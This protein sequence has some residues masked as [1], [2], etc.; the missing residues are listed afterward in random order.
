MAKKKIGIIDA[1]L[2]DHGTRHPNLALMKISGFYKDPDPIKGCGQICDVELIT[3]K[4][5]INTIFSP[6]NDYDLIFVSKVFSFSKTPFDTLVDDKTITPNHNEYRKYILGGTG[7]FGID[8]PKLKTEIEHHMPDYHL[9]DDWVSSQIEDGKKASSFIDYTNFSIGFTTRGC[10]RHCPFC[11]NQKCNRVEQHS[12]VNEFLDT[13]RSKIY[14]WD[15]NVLGYPKWKEIFDE[16]DATKKPF[17]FRQGLD[18]RLMTPEKAERLGRSKWYGDFIFA[19]DNWEDRSIIEKNLKV[20]KKYNP[21]KGT[22]FYLFCGF[23]LTK[24]SDKKLLKDI[25]E[26]FYRIRILMQ[27]GCV[28]Y[29]MR[30]QDY[31]NHPLSNIYVQ[32][33]RWCNQQQFYKKMSFW[34]F[35]YRNQSYY[36]EKALGIVDKPQLKDFEDFMTDYK[37]GYYKKN[38]I[39]ICKSLQ[40]FLDF[41]NHYQTDTEEL[42]DLF[43][44]KMIG[45]KNT[46]LWE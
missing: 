1:D 43:N 29:V 22:K 14:L 38:K 4:F 20:W 15:D 39:K 24:N 36:E 19:F 27:Y 7:F 17:Q 46:K 25:K 32:I 33:A 30:H 45:L 11:V 3:K 2:L 40:T 35:I 31:L 21:K 42:L 28:G 44:I 18:F 8:A 16:L 12:H 34:E 9:Y 13:S 26:I 10:F 37:L 23:K 41:L 6:E 5:D